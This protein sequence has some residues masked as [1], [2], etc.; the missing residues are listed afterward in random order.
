MERHRPSIRAEHDSLDTY[1]S[2][3]LTAAQLARPLLVSFT[4]WDFAVAA[5]GETV[6]TLH[7]M[8][9]DVSL[10]LWSDETPLR[11]VG[12]QVQHSVASLLLSPTIDQR[13]RKGL[14]KAG[15]PN[16]T[17]VPVNH[18][19]RPVSDIP[20]CVIPNRTSIRALTYRGAPLGR[21]ILEVPPGPDVPVTDDYMWPRKYVEA[22]SRSYAFVFDQACRVIEER[23]STSV[24]AYNGRFLHDSA[25]A[26]AAARYGLPVLAYDTGG[27]ETDFDLTID[28]T[29]DWS[30]LQKRMIAMYESWPAPEGE[31][32]GASWFLDRS[33][34]AEE[35]NAKFTGGQELGRGIDRNGEEIVVVYFSS[36]GDEIAELDLKWTDYF[37]G[38]P[39]ALLAVAK[40]CRRLGYRF[41]VRT[42]P[43]KKFKARRDVE[44][45][46]SAVAE[47]RPDLHLDE[48]SEV[49]SYTLMHQADVVVTYGSTTGVEAGFAERPVIV[50]GPS[51]Y[52]ELG[53]AV[54]VST[55]V[56][57]AV[58][59]EERRAG[60]REN[61]IPYGL[62]MKRRG[63]AFSYLSRAVDGTRTLCGV[64][65]TEPRPLAR[66][67]SHA[68]SRW[69]RRRL[70][71]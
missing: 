6:M 27:L 38:Q 16:S 24:F 9:S 46:H 59:L 19:W 37:D 1:L 61:A 14:L 41:V 53:C 4:Q 58:A 52:D 63:F 22:A 49:D 70:L 25:V 34:H 10:A 51:A 17:F 50:M 64:P 45:W 29:H 5:V 36:S 8:G 54:R 15:I 65:I 2:S 66:H 35:A 32:L 26:A 3:V 62:M 30:A 20:T 11:D 18:P 7:G 21:G 39:G 55:A 67:L 47:A 42:H 28:A 68:I 44:D 71:T 69:A 57:L 33:S 31:Q 23:G 56:E 48:H 13:L 60:G 43:H 12:W 40:E